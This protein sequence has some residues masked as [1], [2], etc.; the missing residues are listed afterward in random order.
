MNEPSSN[1]F[2][3]VLLF[4]LRCFI[5]LAI[6]FGV[7]YLLRRMGL[8]AVEVPEPEEKPEEKLKRASGKAAASS[9][10]TSKTQPKKPVKRK[11]SQPRKKI[12]NK[13]KAVNSRS[14]SK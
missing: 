5:P 1:S 2:F 10:S 8:V 7:S 12:A 14:R 3:V 9:K 13:T 6:L 11:T 4:I